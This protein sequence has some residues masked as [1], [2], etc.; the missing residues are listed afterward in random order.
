MTTAPYR[1]RFTDRTA[2]VTGA[3][4]GIG[5]TIA[6]ALA[7]EGANVVVVGR[8]REP[9]GETAASI[10]AAGGKALAVTADVVRAAEVEAAV[11]A[12]VEHF[13]SLDVAVNNAGVFR[14]GA[15]LADLAEED[16][17]TQLGVNVTGVFLALRAEIR[18]MRTQPSG[19]AIVNIASTF[20]AHARHPGAA[21][22]AATKAAVS[23]L[24]R[25]AAL[26]HI[27]E[28]I[29][30]NA[31]S[32]GAVNTPMSLQPGETEAD[33]SARARTALPLGRVTTTEEVA[34]AVL[35]LASDDAA[36]TV[37]TDLVVDSGA[38]A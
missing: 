5:R 25:G 12:A 21:A 8:R 35:H 13:G 2:L 9:L 37:G 24:T 34:A 7:A 16:W 22:Y 11:A 18:Q 31:V 10:E 14:G 28:G 26:D 20:G 17:H 15:P 38:T 30:V 4:S 27:R 36:S 1:A 19:G 23:V 33:R 29:R 32:P 6:R 3:G